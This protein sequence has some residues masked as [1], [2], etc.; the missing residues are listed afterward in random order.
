MNFFSAVDV[1]PGNP[2]DSCAL[3]DVTI[4]G[5]G[6]GGL[7]AEG[8]RAAFGCSPSAGGAEHLPELRGLADD[9][10]GGQH[11][12][13]RVG[14]APQNLVRGQANAR[15]RVARRRLG[16]NLVSRDAGQAAADVGAQEFVGEDVDA[17]GRDD[18]ADSTHGLCE[19]RATSEQV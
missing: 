17:F 18:T 11:H 3:P 7:Q 10:V 8:D 5:I 14:I 16:D 19:E 2:G 9:M 4:T 12:H 6:P 13:Q 1:L 15:R